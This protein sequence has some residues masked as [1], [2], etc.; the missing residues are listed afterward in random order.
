MIVIVKLVYE[1]VM[2]VRDL[3]RYLQ[4][5]Y[6]EVRL[7]GKVVILLPSLHPVCVSLLWAVEHCYPFPCLHQPFQHWRQLREEPRC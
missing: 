6:D 2:Q 1:V 5:V 3:Q 4:A 7:W